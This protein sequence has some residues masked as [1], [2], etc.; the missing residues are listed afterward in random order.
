MPLGLIEQDGRRV[1]DIQTIRAAIDRA[2]SAAS[3]IAQPAATQ[4]YAELQAQ[5]K[6][7]GAAGT[8]KNFILEYVSMPRPSAEAEATVIALQSSVPGRALIAQV[9]SDLGSVF[10]AEPAQERPLKATPA[11]FQN[12]LA[13]DD[14]ANASFSLSLGKLR[15]DHS[16]EHALAA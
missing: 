9:E 1:G 8:F 12:Y 5:Y 13:A 6:T 15:R 4:P 2:Q 11:A 16:D 10:A 14:F 3:T 7:E